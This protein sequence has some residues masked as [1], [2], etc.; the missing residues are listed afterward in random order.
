MSSN[1]SDLKLML[2]PPGKGIY[3]VSSGASLA[4]HLI[5]KIY[6][7][8]IAKG[9]QASL[10]RIPFAPVILLGFPSDIGASIRRGSNFGPLVIRQKLYADKRFKDLLEQEQICD[11][12]DVMVI[13]QL[14]SDAILTKAQKQKCQKALYGPAMNSHLPVSP[15]SILEQASRC[16]YRL[17]P[18]A[19]LI[20]IGG[21][22][23]MS[24]PLVKTL[25]QYT[26]QPF[27]IIHFDAHTDLLQNRLGIDECFGTWAYHA[28]QLIGRKQRLIQIGIRAS[29]KSKMYWES[30]LKVKQFWA[31]QILRNEE[32]A[33]KKILDHLKSLELP[34]VYISNDIDGTSEA[35]A[36]CTGT[37][38]PN[39]L[40]PT[41][42]VRLIQQLKSQWNVIGADLTEV[43][44]L[45]NLDRPNEPQKTLKLSVEYLLTMIKAML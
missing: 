18:Q 45:L 12:G 33:I 4:D 21:D 16:I 19:K 8:H 17:N 40:S 5:K 31:N 11:V 9:W 3:T 23:S 22:H 32:D 20:A 10:E 39:G 35:F 15:L 36:A 30:R 14:L 42:V 24:L 1:F 34:N 25:K 2:R 7:T 44:P 38:E 43:A 6:G 41:F 29:A 28:N 26:Q 13:P 27:A 37:P